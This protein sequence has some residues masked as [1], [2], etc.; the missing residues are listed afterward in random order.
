MPPK[1]P[2]I[3]R[4]L[5]FVPTQP[6]PLHDPDYTPPET[7]LQFSDTHLDENLILKRVCVLPSL[8]QDFLE[9]VETFFPAESQAKHKD[10]MYFFNFGP[11]QGW[12]MRYKYQAKDIR[13][14]YLQGITPPCCQI[15][16][17]ILVHPDALDNFS[18]ISWYETRYTDTDEE[19]FYDENHILGVSD[20][21]GKD[22]K[23]YSDESQQRIVRLR[24]ELETIALGIFLCP[25]A[26][27]CLEEMEDCLPF[28]DADTDLR[29][30]D[31]PWIINSVPKGHA[32]TPSAVRPA[33]ATNPLWN[34]PDLPPPTTSALRAST[35]PKNSLLTEP[36]LALPVR[37][38]R[39]KKASSKLSAHIAT[40]LCKEK[41]T[42]LPTHFRPRDIRPPPF[43]SPAGGVELL[44]RVGLLICRV[45]FS[46]LIFQAWTKAVRADTTVILFDC[47]N[48]L[49]IG[50][51]HREKQTLFLTPLIDVFDPAS[52]YG[53][54]IAGLHLCIVHDALARLPPSDAPIPKKLDTLERSSASLKRK[55]D[56]LPRESSSKRGRTAEPEV[57]ET[58]T[59]VSHFSIVEATVCINSHL[60]AAIDHFTLITTAG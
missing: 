60:L 29:I 54:L 13:N 44:Q 25:N 19:T 51:R 6:F 56:V 3:N 10:G 36:S 12:G 40:K 43:R 42:D 23:T 33:D 48:Y 26:Q 53:R 28:A 5:S 58:H 52:T 41:S 50:I 24:D 30:A 31:F 15:A 34:I 59:R 49:R 55:A 18:I 45:Q 47:G 9:S 22:M 7:F 21:S 4:V 11:Y 14:A 46:N 27:W 39:P 35:R 2:W 1:E 8:I 37:P 16:S 20:I 57:K 17:S 32:P 38:K